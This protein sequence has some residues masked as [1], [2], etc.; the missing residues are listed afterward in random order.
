M[1]IPGGASEPKAA[2][3]EIQSL[4]DSVKD[5]VSS[6]ISAQKQG[7]LN[8]YKAVSFKTQ[9]VA[10]LN[11]FVKVAI[12]DGKEFIHL[13]VFRPLGDNPKPQLARHQESHTEGS[14]LSYF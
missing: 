5:S 1:G 14:D 8:P 12:D 9:V 3:A 4:V 7:K 11:Y 6:S 10:G 2:T 13:R